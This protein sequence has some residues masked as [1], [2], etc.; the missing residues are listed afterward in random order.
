M[1]R[2]GLPDEIRFCVRCV[3]SNQR[4]NSVVEFKNGLKS[5]KPTI[6]FDENGICSACQ[7]NEIKSNLIDWKQRDAELHE[8]CDRHRRS[9]GNFDC[10][11]PGSGGKDSRY[12]SHLLKYKYKMNPLTVTWA[13]HEYTPIG[14]KNFETWLNDG[15]SNILVSPNRELHR[16]LTQEAFKNLGHPF[17]PFI[18]GQR[19]IGAKY[20][21]LLNIPLVFYGENQAEYGNN[22]EENDV[23]TMKSDFFSSDS[24]DDEILLGGKSI[25]Q[26]LADC[27][28]RFISSD[29]DFY[30]VPSI[31]KAE[32][33]EFHYMGYYVNWDPQEIYYFT[34]KKTGF[35]PSPVRT[36]GSYSKYSSIDDKIDMIHYYTTLLKFGLGRATYDASQEIRNGKITREEGISLVKKYDLEFP[37]T[38]INDVLEYLD[39]SLEDFHKICDSYRSEHIWKKVNGEWVLRSPVWS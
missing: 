13:P 21:A 1:A 5:K 12:V 35:I 19:L 24:S 32:D 38:Y 20:A 6:S 25:T 26:H 18:V 29:F 23:P 22:I 8:L 11:V 27:E 28:G 10:I 31:E 33:L 9:D 15:F 36:D 16:Y 37:K 3:I 2:Y 14:W 39:M 7:F 4:P 30:R 17:Q 34:E